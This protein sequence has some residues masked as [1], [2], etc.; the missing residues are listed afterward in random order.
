MRRT[1]SRSCSEKC[2]PTPNISS[3]T[4]IS[5][6][7]AAIFTSATNPGVPGPMAMPATR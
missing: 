3:I 7:S 5:A 4:P 1:D 2:S 6:S